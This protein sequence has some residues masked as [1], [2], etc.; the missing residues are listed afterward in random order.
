MKISAR[1][2]FAPALLLTLILGAWG[3]ASTKFNW[4][5]H[6]GTLTYD[7][8]VLELGPPDK[9]ATLKDG[10]IVAEWLTQRSRHY[11]TYLG[12]YGAYRYACYGVALAPTYVDSYSPDYFLRLTFGPDGKLQRWKKLHR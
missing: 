11:A 7:E 6:L 1:L 9:Q 10:T 8:S 2:R 3:C 12:G 5:Q 4:D